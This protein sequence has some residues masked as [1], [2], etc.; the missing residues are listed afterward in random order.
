MKAISHALL[1]DVPR[2]VTSRSLDE[3]FLPMGAWAAPED[4]LRSEKLRH[5]TGKVLLG[6][7]DGQLLGTDDNRH[8]LLCA[9]SRAGKGVSSLIPNGLCGLGG[10]AIYN[11][12][13]GELA[14]IFGEYLAEKLGQKVY[15]LDPFQRTAPW[16][17]RFHASFN[18]IAVLQDPETMVENAGL[19]A[20]GLVSQR[21][22]NDPH[23]DE[24]A[25]NLLEGLILHVATFPSYEDKRHLITVRR[26]LKR[27]VTMPGEKS[28][29]GL[30]GL[31][32]EMAGNEALD[33]LIQD[34]A[35][36]LAGK[37]EKELDSIISTAERHT[38]FLDYPA[39]RRVL[40]RHDFDLP[41]LK[42]LPTGVV[43]FL[44]LAAG[45]MGKCNRWI[46]LIINLALEAMENTRLRPG[47]PLDETGTGRPVAFYL[48]E[49]PSLGH[50]T[51]IETAAAQ[52]AGFGV[53]LFCVVQDLSQLEAHYGKAWQT[54]LGNCGVQIFFGNNDPFTLEFISKKLGQTTLII[55]HRSQQTHGAHMAGATGE[56]FNTQVQA[57]LTPE[58]VGRY[59]ARDDRQRRQLVLLAGKDPMIL[60]RVVYHDAT[61]PEHHHF[62]GKYRRWS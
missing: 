26:L 44:C 30:E 49:F 48:D 28:L 25:V 57:L 40:V 56:S 24:S 50:M 3:H 5:T 37:T 59:F 43:V 16:V 32:C 29:R 21:S 55:K 58:E 61:L 38:K 33:G 53:K 11:D 39:M 8:V 42:R 46:R 45:R 20:D 4:I 36:S 7:L 23:W 22:Q 13:K 19:I 62:A 31:L 47:G 27:G 18:P 60:Q 10:S 2:G 9:G 51:Q 52:I 6:S 54:F 15:V 17:H 35:V 41:D 14:S 34:F 1:A 12:P